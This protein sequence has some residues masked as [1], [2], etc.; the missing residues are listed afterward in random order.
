[1][2]TEVWFRNPKNYIRELAEI[3]AG[4]IAWDRGVL[5]KSRI[6][7]GVHADLHFSPAVDFRLLC[8]GEQGSAEIRRGYTL[9]APYA[10][11]PTW[12]YGDSLE[13]LEELIATPVGEDPD[14]YGDTSLPPDERPVKGQEHRVVVTHVPPS[15]TAIGKRF[16][17]IVAELQKDYPECI[18]HYHG[19]YSWRVAFGF[20]FGAADVD[21]RITAQKGSVTLPN[22]KVMRYER[23]LEFKPWLDLL[24]VQ[25]QDLKVPRNR[26]MYNIKSALWAGENYLENVKFRIGGKKDL[27]PSALN[28]SHSPTQNHLTRNLP[29]QSGDKVFCDTCSLVNVCKYYREGAVC[30]V[31]GTEVSV[32]AKMFGS[33]DPDTIINGLGRLLEKQADRLEGAMDSESEFDE[34]DPQVTNIMNSLF[35]NGV[36]LAKLL[37]PELGGKGTQ[38]GVFVQNGRPVAA[39]TPSQLM[40]GVV[41]ELEAQGV[42]REDITP[43][44]IKNILGGDQEEIQQRAV[45]ETIDV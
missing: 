7:P 39:G 8:I 27:P 22:G 14:V 6:E 5:A 29:V 3:G 43:E 32:F 17:R 34:L 2:A 30:S 35:A 40:A 24:N 36:K 26:C 19:V 16:V 25:Y 41:A 4:N 28:A 11:Y 37:K 42:A 18:I 45:S 20:G 9:N 23:T 44:M 13:M 12:S 21:A 15:G 31:P 10:V 33:R 1:M 38:V